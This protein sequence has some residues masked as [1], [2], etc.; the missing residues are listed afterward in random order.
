MH[1]TILL[2]EDED[3]IRELYVRQFQLSGYTI[4][5]L[6]NGNDVLTKIQSQHYDMVLLDIMLPGVNGLDLLKQIKSNPDTK[7]I[8]VLM[9]S[10]LGEDYIIRQGFE[11]GADGY[12]IKASLTPHQIITEVGTVLQKFEN[13]LTAN[14]S[15]S[16]NETNITNKEKTDE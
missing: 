9:V 2:V 7:S 16:T 6:A 15:Q 10:N 8:P 11:L 1:K 4:D 14:D 13:P 5:A 12:L 3:F